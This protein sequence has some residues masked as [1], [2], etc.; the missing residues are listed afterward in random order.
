[1]P[2]PNA[3]ISVRRLMLVLVVA[4]SFLV[5]STAP[6]Q[7]HV[8]SARAWTRWTETS[9]CVRAY[10]EVSHGQGSVGYVKAGTSS[11]K[12]MPFPTPLPCFYSHSRPPGWISA[13][14]VLWKYS[15]GRWYVCRQ[16]STRYNSK[17]THVLTI[18]FDF[19]YYNGYFHFSPPC[20]AGYYQT[21]SEGHVYHNGTW[22]PSPGTGRVHSG[23]HYLPS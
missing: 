9:N 3:S 8:V 4:I 16:S 19:W 11:W 17:T 10:S 23:T 7:A 2:I 21:V 22:Y 1:M 14:W 18:Y 5:V 15:S 13:K 12:F 20:G 6:A